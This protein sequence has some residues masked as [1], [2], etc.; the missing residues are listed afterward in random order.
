MFVAELFTIV[1]NLK[2]S[3]SKFPGGLVFKDVALSILWHW[4][5]SRPRNFHM[6]QEQPKTN[7][8]NKYKNFKI[9]KFKLIKVEIRIVV[10]KDWGVTE[11]GTYWAKGPMVQL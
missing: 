9:I 3:N 10:S 6:P 8:V 7:K 5:N 4:F 11:T 1:K 2:I